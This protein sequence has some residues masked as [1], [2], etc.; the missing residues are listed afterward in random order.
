MFQ[1]SPRLRTTHS[2]S[3][4]ILLGWKFDALLPNIMEMR[5]LD[6]RFSI[7]D[8][9]TIANHSKVTQK[10]FFLGGGDETENGNKKTEIITVSHI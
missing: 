7:L 8:T 1:K 4:P 3:R 10:Y 5:L 2:A 6:E 9:K